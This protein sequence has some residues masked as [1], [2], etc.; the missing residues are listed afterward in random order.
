[1]Y[2][3]I[4]LSFANEIEL[5]ARDVIINAANAHIYEEHA[6]TATIYT[7]RKKR[8][9][10]IAKVGCTLS[11]FDYS[12]IELINYNPDTRLKVNVIK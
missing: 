10:P 8:K 7:L 3:A 5:T 2:S 11:D 4:L 1:M 9:L 12:K 6:D